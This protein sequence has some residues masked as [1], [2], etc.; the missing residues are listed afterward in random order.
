M[1]KEKVLKAPFFEIGPKSYL[2][3]DDIIEVAQIADEMSVKY[4]VDILFTCPYVSIEKVVES[5]NNLFVLAPSMDS[6]YPGRGIANILPESIKASGASGVMLNHAEAPMTYSNLE[7]TVNRARELN[8]MTVVCAGSINEI[9]AVAFLNPDVIVAEPTELIGTGNTSDLSYMQTST[10]AI[11][12]I[13]SEIQVLQA[14][15]ISNG[16]DVYRVIENGADGTG[17]SSV[18]A[19]AK[20]KREIIEEMISAVAAAWNNTNREAL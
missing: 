10:E 6:I 12:S 2:Y 13:N 14:A 4:G 15:G 19:N 9:K 3:G 17:S 11:R 18:I 1:R 5:T 16:N 8:L 20:N 7:K